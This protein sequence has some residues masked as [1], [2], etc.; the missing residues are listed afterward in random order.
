M[1]VTVRHNYPFR[2]RCFTPVDSVSEWP[3]K[4][5]AVDEQS[6][7][8]IMHPLSLRIADRVTYQSL[9]PRPQSDVFTF[10]FLCLVLPDSMLLGI[11]VSLISAPPVSV[12][13]GDAKRL[14]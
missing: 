13:L 3:T 12:I 14:Q 11:N 5:I 8:Q 9:D 2:E 1:E 10:D 7:D 4:F 6:N